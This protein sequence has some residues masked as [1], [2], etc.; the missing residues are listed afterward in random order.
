VNTAAAFVRMAGYHVPAHPSKRR[1]TATGTD[2][3]S[4]HADPKTSSENVADNV[5]R[6]FGDSVQIGK[7]IRAFRQVA[8]GSVSSRIPTHRLIDVWSLVTDLESE[9]IAHNDI[10][11]LSSAASVTDCIGFSLSKEKK[12]LI[13]TKFIQ[14]VVA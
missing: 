12:A 3:G 9:A 14:W 5:T 6:R 10:S 4:D 7:V 2:T 13:T 11:D 8:E 1:G